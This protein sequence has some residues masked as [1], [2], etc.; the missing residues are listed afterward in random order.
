MLEYLRIRNLALIEDVELEF[1]STMNV[2]T[3]ETGA[4]KSF[5]LKALGFLLGEKLSPDMVRPQCDR[6]QVEAVF[7]LPD[8]ELILRRELMAE[9]GRSRLYC[10]D[11]VSSQESIR[12]LRSAL[13]VHTSQHGQQRLLQPNY[14]TQL[15]DNAI[16]NQS[17]LQE[18]D[19]ILKELH[20][21]SATRKELQ[22]KLQHL[23]ERRDLLE[24]QQQEIDKVDPEPGEEDRLE[25]QRAEAREAATLTQSYDHALALLHGADGAGL[26]EQ[27]A[28]MERELLEMAK[29]D[30][31]LIPDHEAVAGL[32]QNLSHLERRFRRPPEFV[33]PVDM[34]AIEERLYELSQLKRKLHR[35]L[36]EIVS[37]RQEIVDNLSFLDAC[38]LDLK[39][40]D[41]QETLLI[42][43]LQAILDVLLPA[44][45]TAGEAFARSLEQELAGLGFSEHVRVQ[46]DFVPQEIWA[47]LVDEKA[48]ILWAPN[49]GQVPQPLDRIASGGELSRFLLALVG[50]QD[51]PETATYIFDEVDAGVG[52]LTLN[53][54][55]DRLA[56]LAVRR[57]MLLIT[58]WPQLAVRA[59]RH[60][61]IQK[62]IHDDNTFVLCTPLQDHAI[63][64]ELARMAGGG[65][66]GEA[67]ARSLV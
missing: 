31:S 29:L 22:K 3:G 30:E 1:A 5:I 37:M 4:G 41:R 65:Q 34:D 32:R 45:Q 9:T 6:A 8:Q 47:G 48:R 38:G 49:P 64:D 10:N 33:S 46:I 16:E 52:G 50:I 67:M 51:S 36:D 2:L 40:L 54:V 59:S 66:Q 63:Q 15:I 62:Q 24:M 18:K 13:I 25:A 27:L 57:Q 43:K 44:R 61:Y 23:A 56:A 14:Q 26:L 19:N 39:A 28:E 60:F 53:R 42:E 7:V 17:L 55:A 20:D 21:V 58:H 11:K 12:E 35:S